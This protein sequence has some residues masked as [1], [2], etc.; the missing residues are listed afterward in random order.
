MRKIT[1]TFLLMLAL[2]CA[3]DAAEKVTEAAELGDAF[4]III[5]ATMAT[6][7]YLAAGAFISR[8][9]GGEN[10]NAQA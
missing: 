7:I 3:S 5:G 6:G 10:S 2:F 8:F 1:S 9:I 4:G